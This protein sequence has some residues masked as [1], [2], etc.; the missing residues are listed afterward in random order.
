[1]SLKNNFFS[2]GK[3]RT[4][5][6]MIMSGSSRRVTNPDHLHQH[7]HN[8]HH[9][10]FPSGILRAYIRSRPYISRANNF[11][12]RR[13]QRSQC[14]TRPT[15]HYRAPTHQSGSRYPLCQRKVAGRHDSLQLSGAIQVGD[16]ISRIDSCWH[17]EETRTEEPSTKGLIRVINLEFTARLCE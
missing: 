9:I 7:T 4:A 1:M 6:V 16:T 2:T 8:I 10:I 17:V 3:R 5:F 11:P 12:P 15:S 13:T 14:S